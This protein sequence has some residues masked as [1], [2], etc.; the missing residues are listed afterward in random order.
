ME[1]RQLAAAL[2]PLLAL[3]ALL[4]MAC[5]AP[6]GS[7][8]DAP[9]AAAEDEKAPP[10]RELTEAACLESGRCTLEVIEGEEIPEGTGGYR[11]RPAQG[12]CEAGFRQGS[13]TAETCEA[14]PGCHFVPGRCY[15]PPG[16]VCIC[17]GGPPPTCREE[18]LEAP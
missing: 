2:L 18:S 9:P 12:P 16:V 14:K 10:C 11:C 4:W 1:R 8:E 13:D 6:A 5:A 17:G 3:L 7:L 15:C